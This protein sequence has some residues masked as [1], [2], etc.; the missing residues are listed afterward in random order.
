MRSVIKNAALMTFAVWGLASC[1]RSDIQR[2]CTDDSECRGGRVCIQ[3]ECA[4]DDR[5]DDGGL[6]PDGGFDATFDTDPPPFDT[7]P[8]PPDVGPPPVCDVDS[9]CPGG[10][11][12]GVDFGDRCVVYECGAAGVCEIAGDVMPTDVCRE[13]EV[14]QG[15][16]CGPILCDEQP[17]CGEFGCDTRRGSCGPCV[18]DDDCGELSCD[19]S[20]GLC[21][22]CQSDLDCTAA[23]VCDV[24]RGECVP[25]PQCVI[26]SD[27]EEEEVCLSGTCSFSPE[28]DDDAECRDGFECVDGNCF[29]EIGRAHV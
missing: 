4:E 7:G 22:P 19:E 17:E 3:G 29:E 5:D 12:D 11:A 26:D 14:P 24:G 10:G 20:T 18:R 8:P 23:E 25:R 6:D 1:G 16:G 2:V 13:Y 15:C 28:C 9:D 21:G 27:C